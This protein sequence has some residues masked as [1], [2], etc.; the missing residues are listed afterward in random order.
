MARKRYWRCQYNALVIWVDIGYYFCAV[1][2][3]GDAHGHTN[4]HH[5]VCSDQT[6][7]YIGAL[8]VST[9]GKVIQK[10]AEKKRLT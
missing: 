10:T 4:I 3:L 2:L 1:R 6:V 9:I 8:L 5:G 7:A